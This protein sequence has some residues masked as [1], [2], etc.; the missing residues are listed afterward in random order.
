M[1]KNNNP[2]II[3]ISQYTQRKGT[4]QPLDPLSL[5]AKVSKQALIDTSVGTIKDSIDSV[6]MVNIR[7]WSYKDAPA[8]LSN[9][10][11]LKPINKVYLPD[12]GDTPQMLV[13]RAAKAIATGESQAIL[14]AGGEAT[15]SSR[16]ARNGRISLNWPKY[17]KASYM[18]GEIWDGINKFSN[19]YGIVFPPCCYALFETALRAASGRT[20]QE[21]K[22]YMGKLMKK[23]SD[24]ASQNPNAWNQQIYEEEQITTPSKDNRYINYPYTKLMC[25]NMFIDQAAALIMTSEIEAEKLGI[26]RKKWVYLRGSADF[27]NVH[28]LSQRP[29][30][31]N[32]PAARE[33]AKYALRQAGLSLQDI[34]AFDIYSCFPSIVEIIMEEIG[35][36]PD[37]NRNLTITGGLPYFGGPW[38]NY[39]LHAIVTSIE[40]IRED[41]S[42]NIMVIANGGYNSK[43][44]FGI[45]SSKP[46]KLSWEEIDVT[47]SQNKILEE[48]L[49]EPIIEASGK[50]TIDAYT[51]LYERSGNPNRGIALGTLENGRRTYTFIINTPEILKKLERED[52]VGKTYTIYYDEDIERNVVKLV[53]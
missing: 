17:K 21:H 50:I 3:G 10:L 2:I 1:N 28:N 6:Y 46:P 22:N 34:D 30:I 16:N 29:K 52:I 37:D 23:F 51:I 19:L 48:K 20:I 9:L 39:S 13:N 44:S 5:I 35:I 45:Y 14:I 27:K 12:G 7:S 18:E 26:E 31:Y 36:K 40:Q 33:G 8:E 24:I 38:S 11:G 43:Q 49:P 47:E 41:P 4:P 32:S 15:Y 42:K 53:E 25:S